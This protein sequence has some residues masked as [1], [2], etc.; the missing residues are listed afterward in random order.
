MDGETWITETEGIIAGT[1]FL[2]ATRGV[3]GLKNHHPS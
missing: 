2:Y 3:T 1:K